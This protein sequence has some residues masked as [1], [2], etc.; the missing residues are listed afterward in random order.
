MLMMVDILMQILPI[1]HPIEDIRLIMVHYIKFILLIG[2]YQV[3]T[4]VVILYS[5]FMAAL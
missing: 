1:Q 4:I 2:V 5:M 3:L